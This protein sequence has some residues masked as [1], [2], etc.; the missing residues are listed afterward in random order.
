MRIHKVVIAVWSIASITSALPQGSPAS[1][2]AENSSGAVIVGAATSATVP[3][4]GL[5]TTGAS[6]PAVVPATGLPAATAVPA[7]AS[8]APSS[9][10]TASIV[11]AADVQSSPAGVSP[12]GGSTNT[13]LPTADPSSS[14]N[15]TSSHDNAQGLECNNQ[16]SAG[17]SSAASGAP[18]GTAVPKSPRD[19]GAT[20]GNAGAG[21]PKITLKNPTSSPHSYS[22]S[23]GANSQVGN[24]GME[25]G[26]PASD[27]VHQVPPNAEVVFYPGTGWSGSITQSVDGK[28][29]SRHEFTH[30]MTTG[31]MWYDTDQE[32]GLS[33]STLKPVG[34]GDKLANGQDAESGEKNWSAT[35][36]AAWAKWSGDKQSLLSNPG[37]KA[38]LDGTPQFLTHIAMDKGAPAT[39]Q[40]WVDFLQL[41]TNAQSYI[42]KGAVAGQ[43]ESA[44]GKI[45][46]QQT[47]IVCHLEFVITSY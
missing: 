37:C 15:T 19:S 28:D 10:P 5:P 42:D 2:V 8:S 18:T 4:A 29:G 38:Y 27:S 17:A 34:A 9:A 30:E 23:T 44:T 20:I 43:T 25:G 7:V 13:A 21:G 6:A 46:D 36:N 45:A 24:F 32:F 26:H 3:T 39:C 41:Q 14:G 31:K 40:G 33:N 16:Q 11:A 35:I 1:A 12:A 22:I 47:K